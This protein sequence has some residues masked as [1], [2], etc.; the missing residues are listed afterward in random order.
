ML[1][2]D[3]IVKEIRERTDIVDTISACGIELKRAGSDF[4]SL[5]PFHR[6]KTPSFHVHPNTGYYKC[7]GCGKSGDAIDFLQQHQGMTFIDAVTTL[8]QRCGVEIKKEDDGKY[9]HRKR[10]YALMAQLCAFYGRVLESTKEAQLARDYLQERNIGKDI[11]KDFCIGYA[12]KSASVIL[13][14]A[15]KYGFTSNELEDAGILKMPEGGNEN[16]QPYHRFAGRIV[17]AIKD[18]AGRVVGF[19]GRQIVDNKKTGKYVNS[20]ET[21]IFKKGNI[22]YGLDKAAAHI[23]KSPHREA[24][25]CEGQID[26]IR[27]HTSG[28]PVAVAPQGTAFTAEHATVLKRYADSAVLVFD[29]DSA[30]HKA[31]IKAAGIL[32]SVGM[33][34]RVISLPDGDDPDT[35]LQNGSGTKGPAGFSNLMR[36]AES[37]VKFQCRILRSQESN[38]DSVDAI[39]RVSKAVLS[40]IALCKNAILKD[41]LLT[42]AS[43]ALG[44]PKEA[45]QDEVVRA[46]VKPIVAKKIEE[47]VSDDEDESSCDNDSDSSDDDLIVRDIVPSP[48]E[49]A[50]LSVLA[51]NEGDEELK[52]FLNTAFAKAPNLL[53]KFSV[54]FVR[55]FISAFL[56]HESMSL[57]AFAEN[58]SFKERPWFDE[59]MAHINSTNSVV[60]GEF[61]AKDIVRSCLAVVYHRPD[62]HKKKEMKDG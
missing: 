48:S 16:E 35:Y 17:F 26:C 15:K 40:T 14:W 39:Q 29:D 50:M 47:V 3:S 59:I 57:A 25:L 46:K 56:S 22:L 7:F 41:S 13:S 34:V 37:A 20:P 62:V 24:I 2:P 11:Q 9:E 30:G 21:E 8:A 38:P 19:S 23:T 10:L 49:I 12:P 60:L 5:C 18:T 45:L 32:F 61:S 58:L 54:Q 31:T 33:P 1:I 42:E 55:D 53:Q 4:V 52:E 51:C 27:L 44:I 28:F 36:D 43:I 6:E